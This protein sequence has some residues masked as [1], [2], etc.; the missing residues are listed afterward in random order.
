MVG[1]VMRKLSA[2]AERQGHPGSI[3]VRD[4]AELMKEQKAKLREIQEEQGEAIGTSLR[5]TERCDTLEAER[6]R[7]ERWLDAALFHGDRGFCQ[8]DAAI[9]RAEAAERD[10]KEKGALAERR[11]EALRPF[12]RHF[13]PSGGAVPGRLAKLDEAKPWTLEDF[14]RAYALTPAEEAP[15]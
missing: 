1:S 5:A 8:R 9:K 6:D 14:G 11:G 2:L 13:I 7:L 12:A 10:A 3:N 4:V 15:E